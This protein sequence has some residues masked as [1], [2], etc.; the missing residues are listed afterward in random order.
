LFNQPTPAQ[1]HRTWKSNHIRAQLAP[2]P[3]CISKA[4]VKGL[5]KSVTE[6]VLRFAHER[7]SL[8]TQFE[9]STY[10]FF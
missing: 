2:N 1:M 9:R 6:F 10:F 8:P 5:S 7:T 3:Q 4:S